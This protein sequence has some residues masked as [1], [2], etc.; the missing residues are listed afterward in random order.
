MSTNPSTS[1]T[2]I[3]E[4]NS[5]RNTRQA[6]KK[7]ESIT[8]VGNVSHQITGAKLPSIRQILQ[9][10]FYN[11]RFTK[12]N[13]KESAKLAINAAVIF[14]KQ[15]RIPV[16]EQRR[17]VDKLMKVYDHWGKLQKTHPEKRTDANKNDIQIFVDSLDDL[18]DISTPDALKTIKIDEDRKF[19]EMQKQKGRPGS[20]IGVDMIT[21][22]RESRARERKEKEDSRK[23]KH[24][25]EM[26]Q[27]NGNYRCKTS[28]Q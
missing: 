7:L 28:S 4:S 8:F 11:I 10:M 27:K 12:L 26:A 18:F 13:S 14:W 1:T 25:K 20:M 2:D 19:L 17:C 15:A 23:R 6:L 9:V 5:S 24:E 21:F 16:R 3:A 22:G